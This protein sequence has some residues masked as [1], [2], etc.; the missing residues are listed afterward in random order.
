MNWSTNDV[1]PTVDGGGWTIYLLPDGSLPYGITSNT[2]YIWATDQGRQKLIRLPLMPSGRL[3]LDKSPG[4]SEAYHG[5]TITYTY[6][7][8][9]TSSDD[10]PAL[11]V[12]V[13]DDRCA[14][15]T[16]DSG[17]DGDGELD[18]DETWIYTCQ[19]TV[20]GHTDG[21]ETTITNTAIVSATDAL[22]DPAVSAQDS[23]SVH[24]VH[25]E[26][27]LSISKDGPDEAI[28]GETVHFTY[29]VTYQSADGSPADMVAVSDDKCSPVTGPAPAGDANDNG[30][31]D[32]NESWLYGCSLVIPAHGDDEENPLVNIATVSGRDLDGDAV[33]GDNDQHQTSIN[34]PGRTL[35][36]TKSGPATVSHGQ[37]ITYLYTVTYSSTTGVPIENVIIADDNCSPVT[38]PDPAGD[39]NG[40]TYLDVDESW[41]YSCQ[42]TVPD[43]AEG[44]AAMITNTVT[45][46]GQD[47][48]GYQATPAQDQHIAE[49]VH[50]TDTWYIY[51]PIALTQ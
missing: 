15:V 24:I 45:V 38:G 49:I 36:V 34:H 29:T 28:H 43:H 4:V 8:S 16:F 51:L 47:L 12:S 14:P 23:A 9:Y 6:A 33:T 11:N 42:F 20:P 39:S 25:T 13:V 46:S 35:S 50:E 40:N 48:D 44:E 17:D 7:V 1:S 19:L 2:G 27:A 31:L 41:L 26:G 32:V 18:T 37:Q 5:Q 30:Y 10:S 22:G 3:S 21:E